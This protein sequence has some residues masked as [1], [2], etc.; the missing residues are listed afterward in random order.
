MNLSFACSLR[1][2]EILGLTW[3]NVH[4]S[5]E[6]I[7]KETHGS[8]IDK[9]LERVSKRPIAAVNVQVLLANMHF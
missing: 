7:S 9:E 1:I 3:D 5:V 2:G 4:I 8:T 6:E